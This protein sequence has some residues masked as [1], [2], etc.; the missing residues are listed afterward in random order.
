MTYRIYL[1]DYYDNQSGRVGSSREK[2]FE[3]EAEVVNWMDENIKDED[4][5]IGITR[6]G[7]TGVIRCLYFLKDEDATRFTIHFGKT[8]LVVHEK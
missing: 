1:D 6:Y 4:W 2:L 5:D 8:G 7:V 3:A